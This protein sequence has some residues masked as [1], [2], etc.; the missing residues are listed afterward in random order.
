VRDERTAAIEVLLAADFVPALGKLTQPRLR[1][2]GRGGL[3][4]AE[5]AS[6][7]GADP[8]DRQSM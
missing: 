1:L 2:V 4:I 8:G 5:M 7:V 3:P 6:D